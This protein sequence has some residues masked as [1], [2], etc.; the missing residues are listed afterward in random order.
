L[1]LPKVKGCILVHAVS[2]GETVAAV[3][4]IEKLLENYPSREILITSTTPTGSD[5]VTQFFNGRVEQS[6]LP[7]DIGLFMSKLLKQTQP[8]LVI[9]IETEI[10]P[11]LINQCAKRKIPVLLA[12][13]RL[14][15]RSF[16]GY[17]RFGWLAKPTIAQITRI[18][19]HAT[20]D[21]D[22]FLA[23]GAQLSATKAIGS[24]KFDLHLPQNLHE[25]AQLLLRSL[26][27]KRFIWVA[28][29]THDGEEVEILKAAK[30]INTRLPN[31]LCIIVPRHPERFETVARLL[32]DQKISYQRFSLTR[33]LPEI[34][35]ILL[36]DTMGDMLLF[37]SIA[38]VAFIGGSLTPIG[39]HNILES[40]ACKTATIVGP[41]MFNFK[42][43]YELLKDHKAI[44]EIQNADQLAEH[45][46]R[47]ATND[48]LRHKLS[49][50]GE[51]VMRSNRGSLDRLV[52]I[53][54]QLT[55]DR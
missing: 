37:Y 20:P 13:A 19:A 43:I 14:S 31:A 33:G 17:Q 15:E 47:L 48:I 38:E 51:A 52:S 22:R 16:H 53:T 11:N 8:V 3:P 34:A 39:G 42:S 41:H 28:A 6:F 2:V 26:A 10:W 50:R 30:K 27:A 49:E 12:N 32:E 1:N 36:G 23:L 7:F 4:F 44:I 46:Y 40:M 21:K 45:V 5:R 55:R 24:I 18:A 25:Q 35:P 54:Q 29:S 9:V